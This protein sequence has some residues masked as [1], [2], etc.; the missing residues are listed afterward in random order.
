MNLW[1]EV[2]KSGGAAIL[3][4][5]GRMSVSEPQLTETIEELIDEDQRYFIL[6]LANVTYM[7]NAGLGQLCSIYTL[8]QEC[9]GDVKLLRPTERISDLLEMTKLDTVFETF[10]LEADA[11]S[12]LAALA[13]AV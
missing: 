13:A 1:I 8:A 9:G 12:S 11:I 5:S 10:E 2:R 7:G 3:E 4:L 6:D